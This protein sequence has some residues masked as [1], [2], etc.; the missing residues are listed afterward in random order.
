MNIAGNIAKAL[1][2]TLNALLVE[3]ADGQDRDVVHEALS[4][5]A[6]AAVGELSPEL[7]AVK[8]LM[9][10]FGYDLSLN[11]TNGMFYLQDDYGLQAVADDKI[12][13]YMRDVLDYMK[14]KAM[15]LFD[16][17]NSFVAAVRRNTTAKKVGDSLAPQE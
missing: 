17:K 16:D 15:Q 13:A 7:D 4:E 1:G 3:Y 14:Y 6:S 12:D 2:V 11:A 10:R 8:I 5:K 9:N